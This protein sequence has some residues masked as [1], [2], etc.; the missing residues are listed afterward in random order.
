M[1]Y[2]LPTEADR[3]SDEFAV[4]IGKLTD[5]YAAN[6]GPSDAEIL[7]RYPHFADEL[8]SL[9]PTLRMMGSL[10]LSENDADAASAI[11][12]LGTLGDFRLLREIGRGGMG[13]VYEAE[14]ISLHRRVALKVL[15]FAALADARGLQRFQNE[16]RAAATLH[17]PNIVPVFFVG[18]DK[19]IHFF[20]MQLVDGPSFADII[21]AL[22]DANDT[23][24]VDSPT[25]PANADEKHLVNQTHQ[26]LQAAVSTLREKSRAKFVRRAAEWIAQ[27]ADGLAHAHENGVLHRDIKPGNLL[28]DSDGKVWITDFGLARL[29]ADA[30]MTATG[31]ILG[32]LRYMA[33]ELAAGKGELIDQRADVFGL[34]LTLFELLTL[35]PGYTGK[36]RDELLRQVGQEEVEPVRKLD[37]SIPAELETIVLKATARDAND[38][39]RTARDLASDLRAFLDNRAIAA[40]R[41]SLVNR[42]WKWAMRHQAIVSTAAAAFILAALAVG[43]GQFMANRQVR[44][45]LADVKEKNQELVA[46][47]AETEAALDLAKD[48]VSEFYRRFAIFR[49]R[50]PKVHEYHLRV[51]MQLGGGYVDGVEI[52]DKGKCFC[53][54]L[55]HGFLLLWIPV[56]AWIH[57][58]GVL[59]HRIGRFTPYVWAVWLTFDELTIEVDRF[60]LIP[61][62]RLP[63]GCHPVGIRLDRATARTGS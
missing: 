33:P 47:Q 29:E 55:P 15:P 7:A 24:A 27:A 9:L 39:Y 45:A 54:S 59:N 10:S 52:L 23:E 43:V 25:R 34:G 63:R 53:R 1:N 14:Q 19:G 38:R 12:L 56:S 17:H 36:S 61:D 22:G 3:K 16:A 57:R 58:V 20:A 28:L 46:A 11:D 4:L 49:R 41:P 18:S 35:Q 6:G 30:S 50:D 62:A 48:A 21:S 44:G 8:R 37:A 5:E 32:T 13:V 51:F 40:K 60:A 26:D 2:N 31:D 42:G